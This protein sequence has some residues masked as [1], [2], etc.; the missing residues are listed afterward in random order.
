MVS[1]P[2]TIIRLLIV[3]DEPLARRRLRDILGARR[4]IEIVGEAE[5][6]ADAVTQIENLRPDLVLL[7]VQMP[8]LD[9]FGVLRMVNLDLLPLVIFTT[10]FDQYAVDAFE[11]SAIDYVLKP[12]RRH[13]LEQAIEKAKARLSADEAVSNGV[14]EFLETIKPHRAAYIQRLP[15]RSQNR[16]IILP[17]DQIT[18]LRIDRGLVIVVT[19]QGEFWTKYTTFTELEGLL[20]PELFLR[21]HRQVIVNLSHVREVASFDKH[22]ARLTLTGGQQVVVSRSNLKVVREMLNL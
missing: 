3:D 19:E 12:I 9:G 17:V 15:V 13:R 8:D 14:G 2:S 7:D 5:N 18:S 4:D 11:V 10:A 6:G 21:V 22:A 1:V 16:I 20:D